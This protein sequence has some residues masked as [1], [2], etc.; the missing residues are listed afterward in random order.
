M[1]LTAPNTFKDPICGMIVNSD[2]A[3]RAEYDGRTYYFCGSDCREAFLA[4]GKSARCAGPCAMVI[5]GASGDLTRRKLLPALY[6]LKVNGLLPDEFSIIGVARRPWTEGEFRSRMH[7]AI[8]TYGTQAP[9]PDHWAAL[10]ARIHY[11]QGSFADATTYDRLKA[12]LA[13]SE[14]AHGTGGN[15][16]F[17]LSVQPGSFAAIARHLHE[18]GLTSEKEETWRRIVV[19]KPFGRDLASAQALNADLSAILNEQQVYRIDHFLG[20]E[21]AQNLLVFR[22]G[23]S[24]IEPI[25]NRNYIDHVEITAAE[26]IGIEGRGAFYEGT[27]AFRDMMQNHML[28]LMTLIAMEPPSSL[29]G[30]AVRNEK[31]KLLNSIRIPTPEEALRDTVRG[32]YSAGTVD[33]ANVAAYRAEPDVSP[34]SVVETFTA[35]K[36]QVDNWRWAGVPFYLRTGKRLARRVTEIVIRF[37][38]PPFSLYGGTE[39]SPLGPNLLIL[40]IQPEE[41]ISLQMRA[42]SPGPTIHTQAVTLDFDYA[43]F[44]KVTPATGYE[45]LLYDCIIGDATLFHRSDMVE[46]SWKIADP[47]LST[48]ADLS[49]ERLPIYAPGTWGPPEAEHLLTGDRRWWT[50]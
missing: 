11:C 20:K 26:S 8:T 18:A 3:L 29:S 27:G 9:D 39:C 42:K 6:N 17:Y 5:F 15:A 38:S 10:E 46:A 7:D 30:E 50:A 41:G 16:L 48:W 1:S 40:H 4:R 35:A 49:Y 31:V 13:D 12:M 33:G 28:M 21:T 37:K 34:S 25:W 43:Q 47:I 44:G 45:K 14:R 2:A 19:E 22:L 32:Q 23:N 36:F 24:M